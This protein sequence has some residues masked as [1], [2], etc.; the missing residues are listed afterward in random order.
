MIVSGVYA[1]IGEMALELPARELTLTVGDFLDGRVS[2]MQADGKGTLQLPNGNTFSFSGGAGLQAGEQV[3]LQ[4]VRLQPE[5]G[6]RI[7]N[8]ES[9][10]AQA[11]GQ[12]VEQGLAQAPELL[13]RLSLLAGLSGKSGEG[14]VLLPGQANKAPLLLNLAN[15]LGGGPLPEGALVTDK[16]ESLATVLRQ[17]LPHLSVSGLLK[18]D[19]TELVKLLDGGSREDVSRAVRSLR[20]AAQSLQWVQEVADGN[21]E[22]A[23]SVRNLGEGGR[24]LEVVRGALQRLA[25]L[26]AT[27]EVL[28]RATQAGPEGTM[29]L[30]YR[31]FWVGEEGLGESIWRQE[32]GR[33]G[34]SGQEEK[35]TSVLLSLNMTR[36]GMIQARL[37]L[38]QNRLLV[39]LGAEEESSLSA[40]RGRI[41][42]LRNTIQQAGLPLSALD[43]SMLD[44]TALQAQRRDF[45]GLGAGYSA[46]G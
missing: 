40:L 11:V 24:Q 28:P 44:R 27:Q 32:S 2:R 12:S 33:K 1:P 19:V 6:L 42:E 15:L 30:G 41:G 38:G 37:S 8:S 35:V 5:V 21:R 18:G 46:K 22:S 25:D 7:V 17:N 10:V 14:S 3:R 39:A 9:R 23:E 34:E 16:G 20:Q 31:V 13:A 26:V 29:L 36:L 4:V 43:V 45:L